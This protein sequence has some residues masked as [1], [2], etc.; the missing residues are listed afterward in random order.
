MILVVNCDLLI[1]APTHQKAGTPARL[2]NAVPQY[3]GI[4]SNL[5]VKSITYSYIYSDKPLEVLWAVKM[6]KP[7]NSSFRPAF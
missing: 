6:K 4:G 3:C 2:Y 7:A 5:V 1:T